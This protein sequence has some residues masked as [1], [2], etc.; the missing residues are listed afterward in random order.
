MPANESATP[1]ERTNTQ[2]QAHVQQSVGD[3]PTQVPVEQ[4]VSDLPTQVPGASM[5]PMGSESTHNIP[6]Y[7]IVKKLGGGGMGVVY[8]AKQINLN[9]QVALK[10]IRAEQASNLDLARFDVETEASARVKHPNIAQVFDYNAETNG[11]R[12]YIAI[13]FCSG[14][15]LAEFLDRQPQPPARAAAISE[16]FPTRRMVRV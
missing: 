12:P 10:V 14:G 7:E 8:L 2:K 6:G 3:L 1:F 15:N 16:Y 4:S 11:G 9:R 5:P 13:E